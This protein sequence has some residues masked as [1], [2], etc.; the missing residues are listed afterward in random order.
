MVPLQLVLVVIVIWCFYIHF[1][2]NYLKTN[3][4]LWV[5]VQD[6]FNPDQLISRNKAKKNL[7]LVA[8][9]TQKLKSYNSLFDKYWYR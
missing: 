5:E 3:R 8:E 9:I 2:N 7:H 1:L 4:T 6:Y